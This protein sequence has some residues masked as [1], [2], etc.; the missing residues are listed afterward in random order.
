MASKVLFDKVGWGAQLERLIE[1]GVLSFE[2]AAQQLARHGATKSQAKRP[3]TETTNL[4]APT[5]TGQVE[6][7]N[8]HAHDVLHVGK[9]VGA[10]KNL[11]RTGWVHRKV[12]E[13][14]ESVAEHSFRVAV[15]GLFLQDPTLDTH[16][17]VSMSLLHDLAE[18]IAGDIT[19]HQGISDEEKKKMEEDAMSKILGGLVRPKE[20]EFIIELWKDYED[21]GTP[22]AKVVKDLDRLEMVIQADEY[23][24]EHSHLDLSEFFDS[25][26][27]KFTHPATIE[28]F[29]ELE[30][31]RTARRAEQ[32]EKST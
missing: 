7:K 23:E 1:T 17:I 25:V 5:Q 11:P 29:T 9:Y 13:R 30:K 21:K 14:I 2:E 28:W 8:V 3:K 15:L 16:R 22:E 31:R 12:P 4:A 6:V 19:P 26:R 20:Y 32:K 27:G 24:K 10:L 18:S